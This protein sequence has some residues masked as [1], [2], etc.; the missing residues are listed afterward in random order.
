MAGPSG[1]RRRGSPQ[2]RWTHSAGRGPPRAPW[3]GPREPAGH[4]TR[5]C[6]DSCVSCHL[7]LPPRVRSDGRSVVPGL[8][9]TR[10]PICSGASRRARPA[11]QC[12]LCGGRRPARHETA[13]STACASASS[14]SEW[15]SSMAALRMAASGLAMPCPAMSGAEPWIGSY[16]PKRPSPSDAE[17]NMPIEPAST[18]VSSLRMSPNMVAGEDHVKV[19]GPLDEVHRRRV[20]QQVL[21]RH[22]GIVLGHCLDG[23]AARGGSRPARWPCPP[24]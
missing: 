4:R 21:Q 2:R 14:P 10:S 11:R 7:F 16:R 18:D 20:H 24:T 17:G 6:S 13:A 1:T 8:R 3:P 5:F 22:V 15:R 12:R 9:T 23:P 19:A